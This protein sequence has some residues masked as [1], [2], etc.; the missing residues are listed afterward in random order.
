MLKSTVLLLLLFSAFSCPCV[1][2][3]ITSDSKIHFELPINWASSPKY[4]L[5]VTI[6][7]GYISLQSFEVWSDEKTTLIEFVPKGEDGENWTEIISINKLI[8][9]KVSA[10]ILLD[11]VK[12]GL[13]K[14]LENVKILKEEVSK[15][16]SYIQAKS[17]LSY[18]DKDK[19]E[20]VGLLYYSGPYDCGGVQYTIR[21]KA[22]DSVAISKIENFFNTA[23]QIIP[24]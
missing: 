24:H 10:D 13:M 9:R 18:N 6:P 4:N 8:G 14:N 21:S 20:I 22:S 17:I 1:E 23:L 15:Q 12:K 7:P 19:H 16:P 11:L 2:D 5:S 3:P